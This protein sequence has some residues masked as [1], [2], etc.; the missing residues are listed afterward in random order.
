M[1]QSFPF[2]KH[3][4]LR[5]VSQVVHDAEQQGHSLTVQSHTQELPFPGNLE[6]KDAGVVPL[7]LTQQNAAHFMST[8]WLAVHLTVTAREAITLSLSHVWR[9]RAE[10][11]RFRH[12]RWQE[13]IEALAQ[14]C[15]KD[16]GV[17]QV[18]S[19]QILIVTSVNVCMGTTCLVCINSSHCP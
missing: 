19:L 14:P 1:V 18:Q 17:P 2:I 9:W 6:V 15:K 11:F 5:G 16:F 8:A 10:E 13:R 4:A 3:E 7:P 12:P